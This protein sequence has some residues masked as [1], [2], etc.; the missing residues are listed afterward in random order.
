MTPNQAK[1]RDAFIKLQK[2]DVPPSIREVCAE[3][4][5]RLQPV[6]DAIQVLIDDGFMVQTNAAHRKYKAV[7]FFNDAALDRL[8]H[9][10]LLDLQAKVER[11]LRGGKLAA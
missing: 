1:V 7:G 11:R 9:A 3:T 4:G 6:H 2:G 8:S 10:D 5:M